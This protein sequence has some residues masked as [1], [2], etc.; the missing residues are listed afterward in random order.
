MGAEN[1][2]VQTRPKPSRKKIFTYLRLIFTNFDKKW[3]L[4]AKIVDFKPHIVIL[5]PIAVSNILMG[6]NCGYP[7][8]KKIAENS[9]KIA[10]IAENCGKLWKLRKNCGPHPPPC[11]LLDKAGLYTRGARKKGYL[12]LK[13]PHVCFR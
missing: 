9:R 12:I 4:K 10:E 11:R 3:M 1:L 8:Q 7:P 13:K 5:N 2:Q 6:K